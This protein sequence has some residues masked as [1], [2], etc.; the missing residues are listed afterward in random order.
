MIK[1]CRTR[2]NSPRNESID[3]SLVIAIFPLPDESF[4]RSYT[5][6]TNV[7]RR[8]RAGWDGSSNENAMV[9]AHFDA[10][11]RRGEFHQR[12]SNI[13]RYFSLPVG[14]TAEPFEE[15]MIYAWRWIVQHAPIFHSTTPDFDN[16]LK[17][18]FFWQCIDRLMKKFFVS[19]LCCSVTLEGR[20]FDQRWTTSI[21]WKNSSPKTFPRRVEMQ[22][23][24]H[25]DRR[26]VFDRHF[27]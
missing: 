4:V 17:W 23:F 5:H 18:I 16:D 22:R 14:L 6:G 1:M 24:F 15:L 19:R 27:Q 25:L 21:H 9:H 11:K 26:N 13:R 8:R 20:T 3:R 7:F 2:S 12:N 10:R